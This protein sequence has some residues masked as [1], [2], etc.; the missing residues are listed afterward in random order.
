MENLLGAAGELRELSA[1]AQ[2]K[3]EKD[4]EILV[5]GMTARLGFAYFLY[6]GQ[7]RHDRS[8]H[9]ERVLGN[10]P[11]LWLQQAPRHSFPG[12]KDALECASQSLMPKAWTA[13]VGS[14]TT[15]TG[16]SFPVHHKDGAVGILSLVTDGG[17]GADAY[18][19]GKWLYGATIANFVHEAM[20]HLVRTDELLLQ[21]PLTPRELECLKWVA[22][23]K[24]TWEIS[25]ILGIS[26]HGVQHHVRNTM[27]KF[28]VTSRHKAVARAIACGVI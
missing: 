2:C 28:S 18:G 4:I 16:I 10:L 20:L 22:D 14:D 17:S 26:E 11:A 3:T 23:G 19:D 9:L 5:Q 1:L 6:A 8:R 12:V 13:R 15:A 7:F 25:R 21:A 24:S 27:D